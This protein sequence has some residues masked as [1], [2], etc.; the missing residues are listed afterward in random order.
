MRRIGMAALVGLCWV[1]TART[2]RAQEPALEAN[3][4]QL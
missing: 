1:M 2:A 3:L 4:Q